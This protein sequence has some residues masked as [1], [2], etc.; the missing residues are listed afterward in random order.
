[1]KSNGNKK[2]QRVAVTWEM[3]GYIDVD[4]ESLEEAMDMVKNTPDEFSL[5]VDS[6][7]VDGSFCL[8]TDSVEEMKLIAGVE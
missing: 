1:M 5:P 8:S 3:C 7:Y 4:A 6:N 2:K